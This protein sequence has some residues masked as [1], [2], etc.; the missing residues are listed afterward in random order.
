MKN[1]L[2]LDHNI[3]DFWCTVMKFHLVML[4]RTC[5]DGV[6]GMEVLG[7]SAGQGNCPVWETLM[8][9]STDGTYNI[10]QETFML[11][12][13]APCSSMAEVWQ[14]CSE[15]CSASRSRR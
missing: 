6:A 15:H 2:F 14:M 10:K 13:V 7:F 5:V 4:T 3:C 1:V 11:E 8:Y 9:S 12:E